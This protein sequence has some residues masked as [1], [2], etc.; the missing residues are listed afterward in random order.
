MLKWLMT[1]YSKRFASIVALVV[2]SVALTSF[3]PVLI[4]YA[5]DHGYKEF[6][7]GV[8]TIC[9]LVF[10]GMR[11]ASHL[12]GYRQTLLVSTISADSLH[13]MRTDFFRHVFKLPV[14]TYEQFTSGKLLIQCIGDVDALS[15]FVHTGINLLSNILSILFVTAIMFYYSVKLTLITLSGFA[16]GY[17]IYHFYRKSVLSIWHE[18]REQTSLLGSFVTESVAAFPLIRNFAKESKVLDEFRGLHTKLTQIALKASARV[19]VFYPLVGFLANCY[20]CIALWRSGLLIQ[21]NELTFGAFV[22]FWYLLN[23]FMQPF[24]AI[25]DNLSVIVQASASKE[26]IDRVMSEA[27]E[28]SGHVHVSEIKCIEYS[29]VSFS[30]DGAANVLEGVSFSIKKPLMV[31]IIGRTGSGK[32]TII[33]LLLKLYDGYKGRITIN[34]EQLASLETASLRNRIAFISQDEFVRTSVSMGE[35]QAN[36]IGAV[37]P[38]KVD[39]IVLD[40]ATSNIDPATE[41]ELQRC[42]A[43]RFR[44]KIVIFI[45]HRLSSIRLADKVFYLKD[46]RIKSSGELAGILA[47][48]NDL[49]QLYRLQLS[50]GEYHNT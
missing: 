7:V 15:S 4:Q 12:I 43:E 9:I 8:L 36:V 39:V 21:D 38:S 18:L 5:I 2:A 42:V 30:Y 10:L 3:S 47:T 35:A 45:S 25:A 23:K 17:I 16:A 26:R 50:G 27:V 40:E 14:K 6:D 20:L 1:V 37:D 34:S 11:A 41:V 49:R 29:N 22:A 13:V 31:A 32:S 28:Q 19:S 44:D 24:R 46:G 33:N 48:D